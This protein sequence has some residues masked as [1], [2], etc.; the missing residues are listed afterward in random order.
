VHR[1][2]K[3]VNLLIRELPAAAKSGGGGGG[4]GRGGAE[5]R[6]PRSWE[7]KLGD[8]GLARSIKK[9]GPAPVDGPA[10]RATSQTANVL[11]PTFKPLE[12][13]DELA[14]S[15]R[16]DGQK[17]DIFAAAL[18]MAELF[19]VLEP[20]PGDDRAVGHRA[21]YPFE[22]RD[23]DRGGLLDY[24]RVLGYHAVPTKTG[25][26][27]DTQIQCILRVLGRPTDVDLRWLE[28]RFSGP[29]STS[30]YQRVVAAVQSLWPGGTPRGGG[31]GG[32]G[33]KKPLLSEL[34]PHAPPEGL[35]LLRALL[36]IRPDSR[37]SAEEA[38]KHPFFRELRE[39]PHG[40]AYEEETRR[41]LEAAR[42]VGEPAE[43]HSDDF[44]SREAL[45]G[46]LLR[47]MEAERRKWEECEAKTKKG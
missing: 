6:P 41:T 17:V 10:A 36:R 40:R 4:G 44:S 20:T 29:Q 42:A 19:M 26:N 7:L 14:G 3:S 8:F 25:F 33:E 18:A 35:D 22:G 38:L 15:V 45:R 23:R 34:L 47:L 39:G 37:P 1:D 32:G 2:I 16:Y 5:S 31:G 9:E 46:G 11:T 13:V 12:I 30:L 28:E 27:A 43:L 21:E 24:R